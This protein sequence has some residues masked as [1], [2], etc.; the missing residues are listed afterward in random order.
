M[1]DQFFISFTDELDK[2]A[3]VIRIDKGASRHVSASKRR[4]HTREEGWD[5][6][7]LYQ[8][9]EGSQ[10]ARNQA[11]R[12]REESAGKPVRISRLMGV[13]GAKEM[14]TPGQKAKAAKA[15]KLK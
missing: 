10:E 3:T 7:A 9:T 12:Y 11:M 13:S 2:L 6:K 14:L 4:Q 15:K 8:G 5:P 1:I